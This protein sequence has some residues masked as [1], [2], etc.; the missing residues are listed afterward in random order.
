MVALKCEPIK[1]LGRSRRDTLDIVL[2]DLC[3]DGEEGVL[4]AADSHGVGLA[5]DA[6]RQAEGLKQVVVKVRL[7]GVLKSTF[8]GYISNIYTQN[9][10]GV[11]YLAD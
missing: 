7:A 9:R 4:E 11:F 6:Y 3:E 10:S 5:G 2:E 8:L 1:K